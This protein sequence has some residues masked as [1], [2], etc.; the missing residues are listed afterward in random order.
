MVSLLEDGEGEH[1]PVLDSF[2]DWCNKSNLIL[3]TKKTKEMS[4]DFR[5]SQPSSATVIKGETIQAVTNYKYL[6]IVLD[7]KLKWD[8]WTDLLHTKSQQ[9]MY[10]LKKLLVFN[11]NNRMLQMFY[12]AFISVLTYCIICWFGNATEVQKKSVRKTV[13]TASKLLG[14][15]LPSIES[16]YKDRLVKKANNIICDYTH[17]LVSSFKLLPARRCF[18]PPLLTKNRSKFSFI[19]QAIKALNELK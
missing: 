17:P 3:N 14:I 15:A 12:T 13:T 4:I 11:V 7:N 16:I 9:R 10:F 2:L 8:S 19:P 5:R 1:G 6:G 18:C